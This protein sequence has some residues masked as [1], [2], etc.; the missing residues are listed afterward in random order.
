MPNAL[1]RSEMCSSPCWPAYGVEMPYLL[2]V[3][4]MRMGSSCPLRELHTRH[5]AKS[6]S[7]VPASP[8]CT[9]VM[10]LPAPRL[11]WLACACAVPIA[12]EY[13]T[14]MGELTGATFHLRTE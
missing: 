11:A 12:I 5:V 10:P 6:P 13:C 3:T 14:S 4:I 9:M 2:F 1:P 8:P 7:A